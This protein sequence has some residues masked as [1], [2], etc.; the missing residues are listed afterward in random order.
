MKELQ[1]T[2]P[3]DE[4]GVRAVEARFFIGSVDSIKSDKVA[5]KEEEVSAAPLLSLLQPAPQALHFRLVVR[6]CEL[7]WLLRFTL[8]LWSPQQTHRRT[9]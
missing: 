2:Y 1:E 7:S 8:Q 5:R 9:G 3:P 4:N 6:M